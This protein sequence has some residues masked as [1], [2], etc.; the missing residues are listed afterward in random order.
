MS[1]KEHVPFM[2]KR[3]TEGKL[4]D[5]EKLKIVK[6]FTSDIP[7]LHPEIPEGL[8]FD[9][10]LMRQKERLVSLGFHKR[11][12][13]T[14]EE[15]RDSL[16]KHIFQP[17][18]FRGRLDIPVLFDPR[19]PVKIQ[20]GLI[21]IR[22]E[23]DKTVKVEDWK[24]DPEGYR[25]P[26]S[27]YVTWLRLH[28]GKNY[29]DRTAHNTRMV[30][31]LDERGGTVSDCAGFYIAHPEILGAKGIILPG[32]TVDYSEAKASMKA[33]IVGSLFPGFPAIQA[34]KKEYA[35]MFDK[36]WRTIGPISLKWS[37]PRFFPM[38]CGRQ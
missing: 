12:R 16:P 15:Y 31:A 7:P 27:P 8:P 22:Y 28:K 30:L 5:V 10:E 21:G 37:F 35:A 25:M 24:N 17:E 13:L 20:Y 36:G 3:L 38:V 19:V 29:L 2:R 26:K 32:T 14:E 11:L 23:F 34:D 18:A 6:E 1:F 4:T 33:R 9:I